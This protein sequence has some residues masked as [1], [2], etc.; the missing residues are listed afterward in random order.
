MLR[1]LQSTTVQY[2]SG[3]KYSSPKPARHNGM[4][5]VKPLKFPVIQSLINSCPF[6]KRLL[7]VSLLMWFQPGA[8]HA[9]PM[10]TPNIRNLN[11]IFPRRTHYSIIRQMTNILT[12]AH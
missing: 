11:A 7:L 3:E 10:V 12:T 9:K 6:L 1:K 8:S 5:I 2:W 4:D